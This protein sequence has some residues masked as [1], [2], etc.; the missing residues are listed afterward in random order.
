MVL[1]LKYGG[2][3]NEKIEESFGGMR[4]D[5]VR[6][7][8]PLHLASS[9][10]GCVEAL[11]KAGADPN[12]FRIEHVSNERGYN[13]HKEETILH[14]S[15]SLEM[16]KMLLENGANPNLYCE[17]L[18][19]IDSGVGNDADPRGGNFRSS[20]ICVPCKCTALHKALKIKSLD[21]VKLLIA[22]G[23]DPNL[24]SFRDKTETQTLS[25]CPDQS[26]K[27]AFTLTFDPTFWNHY[28]SK[29]KSQILTLTL[30]LQQIRVILP[31]EVKNII[32]THILRC[33][34]KVHPPPEPKKQG[35]FY[36]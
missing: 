36:W 32:F 14:T 20:V 3:P 24:P 23:A 33:N 18:D 29:W 13:Q 25:L 11:L 26:F 1:F 8:Y 4:T 35:R 19:Q 15:T 16:S 27:N 7:Y 9:S 30:C 6:I 12:V 22:H 2:D 10:V 5:G 28:P 34:Q 21:M 31:K 17:W